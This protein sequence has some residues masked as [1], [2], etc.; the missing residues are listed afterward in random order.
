[1]S[2]WIHV[3]GW[4]L[5][6]FV[7][8]GALVGL[9]SACALRCVRG[10]AAN[11]RYLVACGALGCMLASPIVTAA[12]TARPARPAPAPVALSA[13]STQHEAA[14]TAVRG[15]A[16]TLT[17][18][19]LVGHAIPFAVDGLLP[20]VVAAW[21]AGVMLLFIRL[22]GGWWR[23]RCLHRASLGMA[24][25]LWQANGERMVL[26][27]RLARCVHIVD[28]HLVDTPTVIGWLRPV[29]L[30]PVA[31]LA[32]L[33]PAQVEAILAHEIAHVRR[34]DFIVNAL[35][36]M[37]ETLLF[38]HPAVWWLSARIRAERE[39][40]C[41]E[42]VVN[43]CGD[44]AGYASALA[45]LETW[46]ASPAAR[47]TLALAA[48]DGSLLDRVRR[49]LRVPTDD[50]GPS[51][52]IVTAAL[53]LLFVVAAGG[54]E[55]LA[56]GTASGWT[57]ADLDQVRFAA[58][59][60]PGPPPVFRAFPLPAPPP[61]P[62]PPPPPEV[63]GADTWR[64]YQTDHFE[65][66]YTPTL[67]MEL[68][69]VG[70]E[71]ERAYG[72][73]STD[74]QH[75][76]PAQVP[77]ILFG[78]SRE[79]P[80]GEGRAAEIVRASGAPDRHHL[81]LA[82]EPA[83]GRD[84][85]LLHELTHQFEFDMVPRAIIDG[86]PLWIREGLAEFERGSW[87]AGDQD[88]LRDIVRT[89]TVPRVSRLD[90][91]SFAGNDRLNYSVGH[92]AFEFIDA[93]WS[94]DGVRRF[95]DALARSAPG[96]IGNIYSTA[97]NLAPDD[98]DR[99]FEG[100]LRARFQSPAAEAA[101]PP[102]FDVAALKRN[103]SGGFAGIRILPGGTLTS[104]SVSLRQ[105]ILFAYGI[106]GFQLDGGPTWLASETYDLDAKAE[107]G[108]IPPSA[109]DRVRNEQVKVMLRAMLAERLR[110]T[111][112][113]QMQEQPIYALVVAKGGPKLQAAA[114]KD[115]GTPAAN[116]SPQCGVLIG[117]ARGLIAQGVAMADLAA[118]LRGF[119]SRQVVDK[120]GLAGFFDFKVSPFKLDQSGRDVA[121]GE[122]PPNDERP[123]LFTALQ[124]EVGLKL[125]PTQGAVDVLVIDRAEKP[126]ED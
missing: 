67:E 91:S 80:V 34:H 57:R 48:T 78:T 50:E 6:H 96:G 114:R 16:T 3:A 14:V 51:N 111:V 106:A 71:A 61:P 28:S 92:A 98:F 9:V 118:T 110:L 108:A 93:R 79:V 30:L 95:L 62:P 104:R 112:H 70:D 13:L 101:K 26:R 86:S 63:R 11:I 60:T 45:E 102:A 109:P 54:I 85:V 20:L 115:C 64:I 83:N 23:V 122:G 103:T 73:I 25:S 42:I 18:R 36:T 53:A 107:A 74:L 1:M 75:H 113:H 76:L 38:Y 31:A 100:Y 123:S 41:D 82:L 68:D 49:V 116:G 58:P 121:E 21:L 55:R 46:R 44:P 40:C 37:A 117:G 105:L 39:H 89:N 17:D 27:L 99:G 43:V 97:F 59:P 5:V 125:E 33:T 56:T 35:Q 120:T 2:S 22:S 10:A 126:T 4:M 8:Q 12:V 65:I 7:W 81:L 32:N 72:R 66:Y 52:A 90:L 29:I 24:A 88:L 94:K 84:G 87:A 124:E 77:L 119:V 19:D 69:R 47:V 15:G